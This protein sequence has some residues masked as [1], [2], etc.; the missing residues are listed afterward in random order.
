M[1]CVLAYTHIIGDFRIHLV[2]WQVTFLLEAAPP[3][4][5]IRV[6][7]HNNTTLKEKVI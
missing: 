4:Y 5:E 1:S 2:N 3:G 7:P 6:V